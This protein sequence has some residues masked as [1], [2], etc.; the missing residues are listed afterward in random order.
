MF[1]F[2]L[3]D[4]HV[5][6]PLRAFGNAKVLSDDF[7]RI[8]EARDVEGIET[9]MRAFARATGFDRFSVVMIDDDYSTADSCVPTH[10]IHNTHLSM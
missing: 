7:A 2:G 10:T 1:M 9:A 3:H 4:S 8:A 6:S 5:T